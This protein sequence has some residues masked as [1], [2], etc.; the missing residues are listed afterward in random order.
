MENNYQSTGSIGVPIS[1]K[2]LSQTERA[3]GLASDNERMLMD[4]ISLLE[5]KLKPILREPNP[6]TTE[7]CQKSESFV[8]IAEAIRKL[9]TEFEFANNKI[10]NLLE[11]LEI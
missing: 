5:E 3:F 10:R 6:S 4:S 11:R 8:A 9:G 1:P 2:Q 7:E